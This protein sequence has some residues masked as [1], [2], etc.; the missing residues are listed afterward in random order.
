VPKDYEIASIPRA[1]FSN[2]AAG[3]LA[4]TAVN[5]WSVEPSRLRS[6]YADEKPVSTAIVQLILKQAL[7]KPAVVANYLLEN[8]D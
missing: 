3:Q 7:V 1:E 2:Y 5:A 4:F 6:M 8:C